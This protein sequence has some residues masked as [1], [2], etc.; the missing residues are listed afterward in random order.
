[1]ENVGT[2]VVKTTD[3]SRYTEV[4]DL[5]VLTWAD[6]ALKDRLDAD[7]GKF[8]LT[9]SQNIRVG[10]EEYKSNESDSGIFSSEGGYNYKITS[11]NDG[12][13]FELSYKGGKQKVTNLDTK[14]SQTSDVD[15]LSARAFI[16]GLL[17][18]GEF[19]ADNVTG[20][21]TLSDGKYQLITTRPDMSFAESITGDVDAG[22]LMGSATYTFTVVDGKLTEYECKLNATWRANGTACSVTIDGKCFYS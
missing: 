17:D 9:L 1:V 14:Q 8:E 22:S 3:I 11:E 19:S 12:G 13:K 20:I 18:C 16:K 6:D 4:D 21:K 15:E 5:R 7:A 10:A 2:T